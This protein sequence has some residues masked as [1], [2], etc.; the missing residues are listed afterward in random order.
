MFNYNKCLKVFNEYINNYDLTNHMI[1]LKVVHTYDVVQFSELIARDLGL[2]DA[3]IELAKLIALLHDLARFEQA[4]QF[5]DFKDYTTFDHG[6]LACKILFEDGL[7]RN[8]IED[9]QYDHIIASA[10]KNHNKFV[11]EDGLTADELL[12]AKIIRDADKTDNIKLNSNKNLDMLFKASKNELENGLISDYIYDEFMK[13]HQIISEERTRI[14]DFWI[15][16]LAFIF[17]YNFDFGLKYIKEHDYINLLI[18]R[19]D[20]KNEKTKEQ[21]ENIRNHAIKYIDDKLCK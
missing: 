13:S 21:M 16:Q 19:L 15:S 17:D 18:N 7:I 14:L 11:I 5:S 12:H 2:D 1:K 4:K 20:Y 3:N 10:I 6:D 8:Y 9:D